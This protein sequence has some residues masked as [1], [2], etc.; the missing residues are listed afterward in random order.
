[1][2]IMH[3]VPVVGVL[4]LLLS[5]PGQADVVGFSV[6]ASYWQPELSGDFNS[7]GEGSIDLT[8]DLGIDDPSPTSLVLVLEHPIPILPNFKYQNNDL[9]SDGRSTLSGNISFEGEIYVAGE[10]VTSTFD[11]T[12]DDIILYYEVLDNWVNLDIGLDIKRF[13][14]GVSMVGDTN[15]TTSSIDVDETI[16]LLYLAARF[17]LPLSGLYLGLDVAGIGI[18]DSSAQ[19]ISLKLGYLSGIGLGI[20][21][22]VRTFSIELDDADGLDSDIEYDGAYVQAFFRF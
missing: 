21:G 19:D 16:P 14:G 22:G 2:K 13:D 8:D 9:E 7:T 10:T 17:D 5:A 15:T 12:H 1:M 3:K 18:D 20:E 11:L 4:L 6:G